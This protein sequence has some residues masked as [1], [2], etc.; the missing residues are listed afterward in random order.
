ML[1]R[2][3]LIFLA[4]VVALS[5]EGAAPRSAPAASQFYGTS[6]VHYYHQDATA[7]NHIQ[8]LGVGR[9][10]LQV[11]WAMVQPTP[12]SPI[13]WSHYD[14]IFTLAAQ[15]GITIQALLYA[16]WPDS[17]DP[18]GQQYP[19][20]GTYEYTAWA[21][22]GGMI[23]QIVQRYGY[24]GSFWQSH[25]TLPYLPVRIWEIWNE[26]NLPINNP[27][28][29]TVQPQAYAR[30]L[31]DSATSVRQA[32]AQLQPLS[33][34]NTRILVGGLSGPIG[35]SGMGI[36]AFVNGMYTVSGVG[37]SYDG[38]SVHPYGFVVGSNADKINRMKQYINASRFVLNSNGGNGK[39]LWVTEVGWGATKP[40]L[41]ISSTTVT[42]A[43]Q[44][45]L[46]TDAFTWI[47]AQRNSLHIK[48]LAWYVYRDWYQPTPTWVS[49]AGL[50]REDGTIRNSAWMY[51]QFVT[52]NPNP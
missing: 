23:W 17:S 49:S 27:G 34:T 36:Q 2:Y 50:F 20:P 38:L 21:N 44:G 52:Y 4:A 3:L 37:A 8:A 6:S 30:F 46:L 32:Q 42:E 19:T 10:R 47:H 31:K 15:R 43:D 24:K 9:F 18:A 12:S 5:V 13:D 40:G 35:S 48:Y 39:T 29:N 41:P 22:P 51:L 16:T 45:S 14:S 7:W 11:S 26:P 25:P 33:Q 28:G 1:R